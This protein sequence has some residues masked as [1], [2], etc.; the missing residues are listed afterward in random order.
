MTARAY[1]NNKLVSS[2]HIPFPDS[3]GSQTDYFVAQTNIN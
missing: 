3:F 2:L 1:V